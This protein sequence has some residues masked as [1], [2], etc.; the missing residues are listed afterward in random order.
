MTQREL[1]IWN[2]TVEA[3]RCAAWGEV[4]AMER[5]ASDGMPNPARSI[6]RAVGGL[7]K[8]GDNRQLINTTLT[9]AD[10][11]TP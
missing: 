7:H 3:C 11:P 1:Q 4:E 5:E 10:F 2:D 8:S 6:V 9:A